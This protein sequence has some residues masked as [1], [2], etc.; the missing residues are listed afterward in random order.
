MYFSRYI[1]KLCVCLIFLIIFLLI[2]NEI[3]FIENILLL[4]RVVYNLVSDNKK[5]SMEEGS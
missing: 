5:V 2:S 4:I 1:L 3:L